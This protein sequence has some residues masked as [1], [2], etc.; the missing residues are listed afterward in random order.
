MPTLDPEQEQSRDEP[1]FRDLVTIRKFDE[2]LDA[3]LAKGSLES[4]GIDAFL[5]DTYT[6]GH[7]APVELQVPRSDVEAANEILDTP[8]TESFEIEGVG[9]FDQPRCPSCG[10]IDV[11]TQGE[12][13]TTTDVVTGLGLSPKLGWP[14]LAEVWKCRACQSEWQADEPAS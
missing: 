12:P 11:S 4:A 10:S 7:V 1:E 5:A 2:L 13:E 3:S 8:V 14:T 9:K 6:I